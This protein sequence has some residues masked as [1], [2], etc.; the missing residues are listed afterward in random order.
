MT[1]IFD[2][3]AHYSSRQ[4]DADRDAVMRALGE[5][6][7]VGVLECA[8]HSGDAAAVL[9]LAH[10]YPF[11]HAA[12]G[13][14]PE[15][16]CEEDAATVAT[17]HGDW[18]AELTA[19]RPLFDDPAVIAVGEIGLDHHWPLPAQEQYDL[20]EAQLQLAQ[21]L[22][23]PVSV[24]DREA[25]AE[26][27]ELL[28]Q[29]RPRGVLHCYS[30]SAEDAAWLTAQGIA[31]GFGGA[32]TYKGA[33]RAAKVLA[34]V[35]HELAVLE[36]DC[37]YMSPEPVRGTRN[38]SRNIAHVAAK[39]GEIWQVE[40][41]LPAPAKKRPFAA[42]FLAVMVLVSVF[43]IG[44]VQLKSRYRNVAEIYTS[45]VDKHGNSIQGDFTTLTDTAA[46][47]MRACQKVLGEADSN[48]T[49][50]ADLLAQWQ[51]TAIAPAAQYAV[52]HQLDNAVDAMYTAAKAKATDDALDQINSLDASYVSTQSILQREIAQNY[53]IAAQSYNTMASGFPANVIGTLWGAGQVEL[54]AA[55]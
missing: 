45:E 37:P 46:N 53:T 1:N 15:S 4:F 9:E 32:V 18:R 5:G 24:H 27:Y 30:G 31:L 19:M 7:V 44:G 54:Y 48:C 40:S 39:I 17:Y 41:K 36:T 35:P 16:L 47:L 23:L 38:D 42:G 26:M 55:Q 52:I 29:Y 22:D 13:I 10:K 8:T 43:G 21:E 11:V 28:R 14:H 49:T 25:H 33:K 50:V 2:T 12:L 3:H 51:D 20:F 34:M 6:G